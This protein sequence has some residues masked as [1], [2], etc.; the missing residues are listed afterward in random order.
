M[1]EVI[2]R[3]SRWLIMAAIFFLGFGGTWIKVKQCNNALAFSQY[4]HRIHKFAVSIKRVHWLS[5]FFSG[6]CFFKYWYPLPFTSLMWALAGGWLFF[7][8][9]KIAEGNRIFKKD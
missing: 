1:N 3:D 6:V 2:L 8:I 5:L 4:D 9:N 7:V